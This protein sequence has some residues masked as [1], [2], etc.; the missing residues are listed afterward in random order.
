MELRELL[1]TFKDK[2]M[3]KDSMTRCLD[4]LRGVEADDILLELL[5]FV[6]GFCRPELDIFNSCEYL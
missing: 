1:V 5:D 4:Q 2:G 6:V 3:S